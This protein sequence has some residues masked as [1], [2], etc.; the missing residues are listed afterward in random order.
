MKKFGLLGRHIDYSFSR[1]YFTNK[2]KHNQLECEYV[3]F[4][5]ENIEQFRSIIETTPNLMGM[6]V[7]I[8]Y[9]EAIIPFLDQI[10]VDAQQIGAINTIAFHNQKLTGFNT[11]TYG[12]EKSLVRLLKSNHN[13]AL[14]LGTGGASKAVAFTLKKLG[15]EYHLVSRR[16]SKAVAFT[17]EKLS[18]D[19][20]RQHQLIVNCTPVGTFQRSNRLQNFHTTL[21][22]TTICYMILYIIPL[23]LNS[24]NRERKEK[25]KQSMVWKC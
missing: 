2:F 19:I 5:I 6:N 7:T 4:D 3:N 8:P 16:D 22:V 24:L 12:F 17:Y 1:T 9:K 13:K 10:D 23:K 25:L 21:L 18:E 15:I 20:I 11:D 14:I